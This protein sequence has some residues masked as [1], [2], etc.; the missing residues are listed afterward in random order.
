MVG[1]WKILRHA[2]F[3]SLMLLAA[4]GPNTSGL[5]AGEAGVKGQV[6]NTDGRWSVYGLMSEPAQEL[7]ALAVFIH[8]TPGSSDAWIDTMQAGPDDILTL[9]LDRPGFGKTDP[10]D[11]V[12]DLKSQAEAVIQTLESYKKSHALKGK[13]NVLIGHSYGGP[14][15]VQVALDRP[16]LVNAIVLAAAPLDPGMEKVHWM[17]RVATWAPVKMMIGHTLRTSN[18]ELLALK[19]ELLAMQTRL[20]A[21]TVPVFI[22]HGTKDTLVPIDNVAFM[23]AHIP[24]SVIC[25]TNVIEGQNHFLPWNQI[26]A[27]WDQINA[28]AALEPGTC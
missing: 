14:V 16:D 26:D 17:Q 24:P 20:P 23:E 2:W 27:L 1:D 7:R 10:R 28:A 22:L 9:A 19:D 4:C 21:L 25:D 15:A 6:I 5:S 12:T 18:A 8:G 13:P 3:F 11:A